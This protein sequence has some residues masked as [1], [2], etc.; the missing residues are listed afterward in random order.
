MSC[1]LSLKKRCS[2]LKL[3]DMRIKLLCSKRKNISRGLGNYRP[4][5]EPQTKKESFTQKFRKSQ[6]ASE[7]GIPESNTTTEK[8]T[9]GNNSKTGISDTKSRD[10]HFDVGVSLSQHSLGANLPANLGNQKQRKTLN[11]NNNKHYSS[12]QKLATEGMLEEQEQQEEPSQI[13]HPQEPVAQQ[14]KNK[15]QQ[16]T[17]LN[18]KRKVRKTKA[19]RN[20]ER[21]SRTMKERVTMGPSRQWEVRKSTDILNPNFASELQTPQR[22]TYDQS[23]LFT[24]NK[25]DFIGDESS[26]SNTFVKENKLA[27]TFQ[28]KRKGDA[29][30]L[31]EDST[32][33]V[34]LVAATLLYGKFNLEKETPTTK[35]L[36]ESPENQ[37]RETRKS[38]EAVPIVSSNADS[39][40][41]CPEIFHLEE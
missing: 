15:P 40:K 17:S 32:G 2:T 36:E 6:R 23:L 19:Q 29:I 13:K 3:K 12:A 39:S 21:L 18:A 27:Q 41:D 31:S 9:G 20:Q 8:F 22:M 24:P 28:K 14:E 1:T 34:P 11:K 5:P 16:L 35:E 7:V 10:S 26:N 25:E 4:T 30:K 33:S 38:S 37:Q